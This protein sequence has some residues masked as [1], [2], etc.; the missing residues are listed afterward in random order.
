MLC[1]GDVT[2]SLSATA[3]RF[4]VFA[5]PLRTMQTSRCFSL[6]N[7]FNVVR[8]VQWFVCQFLLISDGNRCSTDSTWMPEEDSDGRT[9]GLK[10]LDEWTGAAI[11]RAND[12][13]YCRRNGRI[14]NSVAADTA[15]P[16][17]ATKK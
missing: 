13:Y 14:S 16:I 2:E 9:G 12:N 15:N 7:V 5:K 6:A 8:N 17:V 11:R 1:N 10:R 4:V 3:V